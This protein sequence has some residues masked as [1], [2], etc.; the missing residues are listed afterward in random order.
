ML[1]LREISGASKGP[2]WRSGAQVKAE[3]TLAQADFSTPAQPA[4]TFHK[5]FII[6]TEE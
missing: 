1:T 5:K 2:S 6:H 4:Q 3:K